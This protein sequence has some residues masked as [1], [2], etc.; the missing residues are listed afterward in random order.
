MNN[1]T[2]TAQ[3]MKQLQEATK[4]MREGVVN[5]FEVMHSHCELTFDHW[6]ITLELTDQFSIKEE[7]ELSRKNSFDDAFEA[8]EKKTVKEREIDAN[9]QTRKQRT[10]EI[11]QKS[12][13]HRQ[14]KFLTSIEHAT[15]LCTMVESKIAKHDS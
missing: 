15:S 12:T 13:F 7:A 10:D 8:S 4:G 9:N 3:H 6:R 1:Y 11:V 2:L 5:L 14:Q